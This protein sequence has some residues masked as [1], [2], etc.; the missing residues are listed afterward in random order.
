LPTGDA[1]CWRTSAYLGVL[2]PLVIVGARLRDELLEKNRGLPDLPASRAPGRP[3]LGGN[4]KNPV[5]EREMLLGLQIPPKNLDCLARFD[6]PRL[7]RCWFSCNF[8][9]YRRIM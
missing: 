5:A 3:P 4:A 9:A 2:A 7:P 8:F 1:A 6:R